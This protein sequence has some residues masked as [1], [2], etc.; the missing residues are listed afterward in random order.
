MSE[1]VGIGDLGDVGSFREWN[2]R[3]NFGSLAVL[4]GQLHGPAG[5]RS[6]DCNLSART[7]KGNAICRMGQ[8]SGRSSVRRRAGVDHIL[9][10]H[11]ASLCRVSVGS[12]A[13]RV[14]GQAWRLLRRS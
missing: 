6:P 1:W 11:L 2:V 8:I 9:R 13:V 7:A 4:S 14:R 10:A 5:A 12:I 3:P